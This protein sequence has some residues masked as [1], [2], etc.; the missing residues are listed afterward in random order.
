MNAAGIPAN[1]L[2]SLK[3]PSGVVVLLYDQSDFK[4]NVA[5]F[6]ND[7]KD[8]RGASWNDRAS[9]MIIQSADDRR[10]EQEAQ[11]F[12]SVVQKVVTAEKAAAVPKT[13]D[14][15]CPP[16]PNPL[17]MPPASCS[18]VSVDLKSI[19]NT[20][21]TLSRLI[22]SQHLSDLCKVAGSI[23]ANTGLISLFQKN[24]VVPN[25]DIAQQAD[26]LK[27]YVDSLLKQSKARVEFDAS[28]QTA[29]AIKAKLDEEK[30]KVDALKK[31]QE[32]DEKK[33]RDDM[34]ALAKAQ[35]EQKIKDEKAKKDAADKAAA[36]KK[37]QGFV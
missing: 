33:L 10:R 36:A 9:S 19:S 27:D 21:A 13:C 20:L 14:T 18:D 3:I 11:I 26:N 37:V 34:A 25:S 5:E 4:G 32:A 2:S 12:Q 24:S 17:I 22:R 35:A 7:I 23:K 28:A 16:I 15:C 1:S 31:K 30:A 6:K 8:L 29:A